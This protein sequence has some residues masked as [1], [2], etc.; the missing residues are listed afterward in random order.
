MDP[1][2]V[3]C[4]SSLVAIPLHVMQD[5]AMTAKS[6][7]D[8]SHIHLKDLD[9]PICFKAPNEMN[10][11][12]PS[13]LSRACAPLKAVW[14]LSFHHVTRS[15]SFCCGNCTSFMKQL[16]DICLIKIYSLRTCYLIKFIQKPWGIRLSRLICCE[17]LFSLAKELILAASKASIKSGPRPSSCALHL[18]TG[19]LSA[20]DMTTMKQ[21]FLKLFCKASK[22]ISSVISTDS[23]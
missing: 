3:A 15:F 5:F 13:S 17:M 19:V 21:I 2:L 8:Q 6:T 4:P 23:T 11:L 9:P 20:P 14:A 12:Q 1:K 10:T 16:T 22:Y 7:V 18:N